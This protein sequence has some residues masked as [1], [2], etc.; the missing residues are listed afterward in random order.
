MQI[1]AV[2]ATLVA[3]MLLLAGCATAPETY[4]LEAEIADP[5]GF[6]AG[7]TAVRRASGW[8]A[9]RRVYVNR[10]AERLRL[11]SRESL[12]L[13]AAVADPA[14]YAPPVPLPPETCI[15]DAPV[16]L[17]VIANG[18][19]RRLTLSCETSPGLEVVLRILFD[20]P[21][22]TPSH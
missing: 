16:T 4:R 9:E 2:R 21:A 5:L 17:D 10:S 15:D 6:P 12:A 3:A 7:A 14:L 11:S 22:S 18:E 19:T 13:D 1:L 8:T 20:W